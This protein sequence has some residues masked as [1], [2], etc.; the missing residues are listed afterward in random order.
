MLYITEGLIKEKGLHAGNMIR[1]LAK[2]VSGGGGGQPF[3]ATAGGKNPG[4]LDN[5]FAKIEGM[6]QS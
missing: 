1:E 5:A 4:G 2:E 3:F 6:L